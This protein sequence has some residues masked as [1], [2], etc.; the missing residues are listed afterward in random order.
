MFFE[1]VF[2][3]TFKKLEKQIKKLRSAHKKGFQFSHACSKRFED[4]NHLE[5]HQDIHV[6]GGKHYKCLKS[7]RMVWYVDLF[8]QLKGAFVRM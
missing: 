6:I 2:S 4:R 1:P 8:I 3:E 7:Q 5:E